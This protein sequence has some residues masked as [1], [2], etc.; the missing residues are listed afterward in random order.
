MG[1]SPIDYLLRR[2][3]TESCEMMRDPSLNLTQVASHAGFSDSNY[4][5]RQFKRVMGQSPRE[6]RQSL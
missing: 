3:V 6:Y 5:S 1:T 2:R 4:F